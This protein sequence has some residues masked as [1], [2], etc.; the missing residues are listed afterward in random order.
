MNEMQAIGPLWRALTA[1]DEDYVLATIVAVEGSG[2]RK[3]GARMIVAPDG[4]RSGT[5]SGGCL[6]AEVAQKA[7]WHTENG[8][9]MRSY[10]THAE[11]GDVPY[12]MGCGGVVHILLERRSTAEPLLQAMERAYRDRV[13]MAVA[14]CTRGESI[15]TRQWRVEG[16]KSAD[17]APDKAAKPAEALAALADAA[18]LTRQSHAEENAFVEWMAPRTGLLI[19]GAGNDAQPLVRLAHELG[20]HLTVMDGRSHLATRERFPL[21]D[22]VLPLNAESWRQLTLRPND[23]AAL[24]T[25]SLDQDTTALRFLLRHHPTMN[26]THDPA[27]LELAYLGVLG[28]RSR[29][30]EIVEK[31]AAEAAPDNKNSAPQL[32]QRRLAQHWMDQLHAPMGLDLGGDGAAAVALSIV[33]EIQRKLQQHSGQP[34]RDIRRARDHHE[35]TKAVAVAG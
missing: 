21:A 35:L 6:E 20:W 4:R 2:Y 13:A 16:A 30:A 3:P 31:L 9:V 26:P 24:M 1:A 27:T 15:A 7:F 8:P 34:L 29:T 14:T 18:L 25:H 32:T 22:A 23:V 33:A 12:G 11:D 5:I 10:S 19:V 28:P 17:A